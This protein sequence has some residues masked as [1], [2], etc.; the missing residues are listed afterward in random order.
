MSHLMA[1][2]QAGR[3]RE[4]HRQLVA[5][6]VGLSGFDVIYAVEVDHG[7]VSQYL[8]IPQWRG[9]PSPDRDL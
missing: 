6:Q 3:Y 9:Y 5:V 2:C 4:V 8:L 1:M 7:F